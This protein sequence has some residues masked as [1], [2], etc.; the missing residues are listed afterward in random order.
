MT[1]HTTGTTMPFR[2]HQPPSECEVLIVGGGPVGLFTAA[3]LDAEGIAVTVLEQRSGPSEHSKGATVHPR[4]L[5]VLNVLRDSGGRGL[6]DALAAQ[7]T[8]NSGTHFAL[9]PS[10]LDYS[11]L[12]T[13]FP[14]VLLV[15]QARTERLLLDHLL[16]H[17]VPVLYEHHVNA[18]TQGED[19]VRARFGCRVSRARYLVGADG[20]HSLVRKQARIE[21]R[22]APATMLSFVADVQLDDP[23]PHPVQYWDPETGTLSV[24]PLPDG[25]HRLY[26]AEPTDTRLSPEQVAS[27]NRGG[28]TRQQLHDAM[29]RI[30][31]TD[32]ELREAVWTSQVT[33][34]TR[35]V[36]Q[37]RA[38]RIFLAGDS[39]HVHF[40]AGGQGLNA[41]LQDAA[42]LAWKLAAEVRGRA[43]QHLRDG[44][45]SYHNERG[46]IARRLTL[47]TLAQ[48]AVMYNFSPA[49]AALRDL[50]STLIAREP[51]TAGQLAGWLSG[52]T[53]HYPP[54]QDTHPLVGRRMPD[55]DLLDRLRPGRFLLAGPTGTCQASD[56]PEHT[57]DVAHLP[58]DGVDA[59]AVLV[60]PD[61][62]VANAWTDATADPHSIR[63]AWAHWTGAAH[64]A[65]PADPRATPHR[66][67]HTWPARNEA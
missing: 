9:L 45:T 59:S 31:G 39:A 40:P 62:H 1:G 3:L 56:F 12:P 5:E 43:P 54:P 47:N 17:G 58:L 27:R 32:F 29:R 11:A 22:G 7:G 18:V 19:G 51:G 16:E 60:R 65:W 46:P 30:T 34:A 67:R 42:N 6:G 23:P 13:R 36:V 15:P 28:P 10:L 61:G 24:I 2:R 21:F 38:G 66:P 4:T 41:G 25:Q 8:R 64:P 63:T 53:V 50:L 48:T 33:D 37:H 49:G 44:P 14:F 26:G 57:I 55:P 35:Y 20:A 52:L